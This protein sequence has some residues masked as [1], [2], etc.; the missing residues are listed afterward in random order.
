MMETH[1]FV[2]IP[3]FVLKS[4]HPR[5]KKNGSRVVTIPKKGGHRCHSCGHMP[6]FPKVLPSEAYE[7]WEAACLVEC[8]GIKRALL[9]HGVVLPI[10]APVSIE[11]HVYL[12]P[13]AS[14][15]MRLDCGDL[16]GYLQAIG[17][18]LQA[19]EILKDDRLVEDWDGSCRHVD[20]AQPRV[21]VYIM[22][23]GDAR[24]AQESTR[25]IDRRALAL[26]MQGV[27]LATAYRRAQEEMRAKAS[28]H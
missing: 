14:G 8:I 4:E 17:D 16:V 18:L 6:G 19:A 24:P 23:V 5:T 25:D 20:A 7:R 11:A 22:V 9:A 13:A 26:I 3:G 21:E 1:G 10:A 28:L 12:M 2:L 27:D 15:K